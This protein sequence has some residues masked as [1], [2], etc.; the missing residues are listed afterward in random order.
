MAEELY[1]GETSSGVAGDLQQATTVVAQMVGSMG[2]AGSLVSFDAMQTGGANLV[3]KVL[4]FDDSRQQV[5]DL[6]QAARD[7]VRTMLDANRH[8]VEALRD[9]L[10]ERD[11]LLGDEI[12]AVI[13]GAAAPSAGPPAART[14]IDLG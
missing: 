5:E 3:A 11:E 9:A 13:A 12:L 1:F 10:L 4:S 2:M 8:V 7:R 6:L 14:P